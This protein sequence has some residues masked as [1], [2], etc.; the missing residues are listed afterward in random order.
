MLLCV[1]VF[2]RFKVWPLSS[3]AGS[4]ANALVAVVIVTVMLRVLFGSRR[5]VCI[6]SLKEVK[7]DVKWT[8]LK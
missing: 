5:S 2:F 6:T 4:S 8:R 1:A 3:T 7:L